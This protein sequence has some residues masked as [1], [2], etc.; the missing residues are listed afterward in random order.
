MSI[1]TKAALL[2]APYQ[3]ELVERE[4]VVGLAHHTRQQREVWTTWALRPVVK[5]FIEVKPLITH[6]FRLDNIAAAFDLAV[7]DDSAIKI[8][9]RP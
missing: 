6:E 2:K 9:V 1:I 5:G 4:L 3:I 7:K 8:V